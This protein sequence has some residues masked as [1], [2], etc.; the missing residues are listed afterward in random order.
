M[1]YCLVFVLVLFLNLVSYSQITTTIS[2]T[3]KTSMNS[4]DVIYYNSNRKLSWKDFKGAPN[5]PTP[6]AAITSSGFGYKAGMRSVN[7]KGTINVSIYCYFN[8]QNSWVRNGKNTAY[9]LNHEQHHFDATYLAAKLFIAKVKAAGLTT[10]NMNA[11]LDKIYKECSGIL[12][13]MQNDYDGQTRN[14]RQED[15]Q[16]EWNKFFEERLAALT[17]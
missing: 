3:E 2:W 8:K 16:A 13:K 6:I 17:N 4:N 7:G 9:I 11:S 1:K 10:E 12:N 5:Q 14:G 15:K